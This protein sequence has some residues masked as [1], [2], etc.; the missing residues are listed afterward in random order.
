MDEVSTDLVVGMSSRLGST[1]G[2]LLD[3]V[4]LRVIDAHALT[5]LLDEHKVIVV[6]GARLTSDEHLDLARRFGPL[7]LH[8]YLSD[9]RSGRPHVLVMEGARALADTF[10]SDESFLDAPPGTCVLQMHTLPDSGGATT[11]M[12]LEAAH[13][14]L[15]PEVR[16]QLAGAS[17]VHRTLDGDRE[18]RHP[19]VCAHPRTGNPALY[20]SRLYTCAIEGAGDDSAGFLGALL[21]HSENPAFACRL[22]W[23]PGDVVIWDNCCTSHRVAD[24]FTTY[25]RVERVAGGGRRP[26][27]FGG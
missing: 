23:G 26:E 15:P 16:E 17:A 22:E 1:C 21:D 7:Q 11:W 24:D 10:H 13:A 4:D 18:A 19:V 5:A 2:V 3:G 27:R 6:R 8:P 25:R 9:Q 20:V 14:A 12:D